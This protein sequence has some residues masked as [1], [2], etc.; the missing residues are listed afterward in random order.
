MIRNPILRAVSTGTRS[1]LLHKLRSLLTTL[2]VLFGTASVIAMLAVGEGASW[3]AQEQIKQLGS[4]N[5]ILRSLKPPED[6]NQG[7][8]SARVLDY[9]ITDQDLER[10]RT[11]FPAVE[12]VVPVREILKEV[13]YLERGANARVL[14]TAP[15]WRDVTGRLVWEGRFLTESDEE[16][17]NNVCVLGTE[18]ARSLFPLETPLGKNIKVGGD[19]FTVV[20]TLAPRVPL[21]T[22]RARPGQDV[23]GEVFIPFETAKKWYGDMQVRRRA[24]SM[25]M[26][27][28][29]LHEVVIEVDHSENVEMVG[30]AAR[31]MLARFHKK[32]DW[33]VVVPLELLASAEA[34]KR[35]FNTL[36]GSIAGISLL[37][38]GI[39]IMNVMLATVTE[40]TREIGIRR[41]LGAK[42]RHIVSQFLVETVVLSVG[43]GLLGV[44]VGV[45]SPAIIERVAEQKTIVT[46]TAPLVAFL[47]SAGVGIV[48]GLYPAWRA[49][50]MDPVEALRHG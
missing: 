17:L 36:L 25:D 43:G 13:R 48:F 44:L 31:E 22:D 39:G 1:L 14:S 18:V 50:N 6:P 29:D 5:V 33:E 20:G 19:Y 41:A 4:Q 32:R 21:G 15:E 37:V 7:N 10:V 3:E 34:T 49:A 16:S 11:T 27:E 28:V 30:E 35:R 8:Q 2:G 40:R 12:R 26:E 38:G 46:L 23:T 24:G 9:G 45:L 47:I 42:R